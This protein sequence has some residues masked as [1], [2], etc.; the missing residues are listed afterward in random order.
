MT[1]ISGKENKKYVPIN[2][3]LIDKFSW[4]K[5]YFHRRKTPWSNYMTLKQKALMKGR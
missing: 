1:A 5:T 2:F 3:S 4:L